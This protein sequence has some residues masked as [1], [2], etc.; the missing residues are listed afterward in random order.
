MAMKS[1]PDSIPSPVVWYTRRE[2]TMKRD[3]KKYRYV[4]RFI[5]KSETYVNP[6]EQ[7]RGGVESRWLH[8]L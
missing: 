8:I 5:D 7:C 1:V 2:N 6:C 3:P 4:Y